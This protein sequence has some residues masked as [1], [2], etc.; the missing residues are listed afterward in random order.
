[1][2]VGG[3]YD[4]PITPRVFQGTTNAGLNT[5]QALA[6]TPATTIEDIVDEAAEIMQSGLLR[7][8]VAILFASLLLV[9]SRR[10]AKFDRQVKSA[11]FVKPE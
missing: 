8:R 7:V 4:N 10:V 6:T 2:T 11:T 9:L 5:K 1:M 3:S